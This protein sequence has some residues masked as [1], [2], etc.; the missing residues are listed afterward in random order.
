FRLRN[1]FLRARVSPLNHNISGGYVPW[2]ELED[3]R[4]TA[5][6]PMEKF[7]PRALPFAGVN[8]GP[9]FSSELCRDFHYQRALLIVFEY[10][11]DYGFGWGHFGR[12]RQS[13]V[14]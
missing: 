4:Y 5:T 8:V 9:E 7:R 1:D 12:K 11:H 2:A 3:N 6:L 13:F 14:V 10:R